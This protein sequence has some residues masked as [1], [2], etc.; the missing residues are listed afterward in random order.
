MRERRWES[1]TNLEFGG[2]LAL[3]ERLAALGLEPA[4]P[5]KDVICYVE[6]WP[7]EAP[8]DLDRLDPWPTE[9]VTLVHIREAWRGDFF[10]LAGAYHTVYRRH[11][12]LGT[13]CSV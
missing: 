12:A 10:L 3:G 7:V 2:V 5:A 6:E 11:Q 1:R 9:D 8:E 4:V 13:Y